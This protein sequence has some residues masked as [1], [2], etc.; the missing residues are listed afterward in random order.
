M[1]SPSKLQEKLIEI[2]LTFFEEMENEGNHNAKFKNDCIFVKGD[3]LNVDKFADYRYFQLY[4]ESGIKDRAGLTRVL[5]GLKVKGYLDGEGKTGYILTDKHL[6]SPIKSTPT[7][8]SSTTKNNNE[9][10]K[11]SS[12]MKTQNKSTKNTNIIIT[13]DDYIEMDIDDQIE[14][15]KKKIEKL[16]K[17]KLKAEQNLNLNLNIYKTLENN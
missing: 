9:N 13:H 6:N 10:N 5:T 4:E 7:K 3:T 8:T 17:K 12:Q 14:Q 15:C 2:I 1:A 16:E 11:K